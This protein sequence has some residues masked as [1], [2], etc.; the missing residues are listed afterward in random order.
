MRILRRPINFVWWA[1]IT[2]ACL[3][4]LNIYR[5]VASNNGGYLWKLCEFDFNF[6]ECNEDFQTVLFYLYQWPI[7][8]LGCSNTVA[9]FAQAEAG[10]LRIGLQCRQNRPMLVRDEWPMIF[11]LIC[12]KIKLRQKR[13]YCSVCTLRP[14][15]NSAKFTPNKLN[16]TVN[17][18]DKCKNHSN[19]RQ[20]F[21]LWTIFGINH[22]F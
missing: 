12:I 6:H 19:H 15:L 21:H 22:Y 13:I 5:Q 3:H 20:I 4:R 1:L 11:A 8:K 14:W 18:I 2:P 7:L 16:D 10:Y 9:G 17:T